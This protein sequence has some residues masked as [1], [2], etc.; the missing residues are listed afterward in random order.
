MTPPIAPSDAPDLTFDP[1]QVARAARGWDEVH[2]EL[3]G[4][5]DAMAGATT[6]GFTAPVR[7]AASRCGAAWS[8]VVREIAAAAEACA[9]GVRASAARIIDADERIAA[10]AGLLEARL[11]ELR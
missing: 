1:D 7:A 9:D 2:L 10:T 4:I 6:T 3:R 11:R 5:A 8:E